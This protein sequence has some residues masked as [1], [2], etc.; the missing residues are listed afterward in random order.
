MHHWARCRIR[1][2]IVKG[3]ELGVRVHVHDI[4]LPYDY[5]PAVLDTLANVPSSPWR[6]VADV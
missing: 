1:H 3:Y 4:F 6:Q 2:G 5:K